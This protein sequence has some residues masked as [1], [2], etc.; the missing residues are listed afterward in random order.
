MGE[1][2]EAVPHEPPTP[3]ICNTPPEHSRNTET[4]TE[5]M[6]THSSIERSASQPSRIIDTPPDGGARAWM[7]VFSTFLVV[8]N[9][10]GVANSF[11]VF[12]PYF[13]SVFSRPQSDVS[14]IGSFEVFLLF[15]VG[16]FT[17]RWTDMGF[18][19]P[20]FIAGFFL[21]ILG[22]VAASFCTTYWQFFLAQGICLGLGNGCL[23]CPCMAVTSTYFAKRRSLA[24]G[25]TAAGA[26]VGGLTI[27]SMVRQLLPKIGLGWTIRAIALI[28]VVT[29]IVAGLLIKTRIPPR[30]AAPLVEWAAFQ[31]SEYSFYAIGAFMCFWG[32]Y[33]AFHFLA[34]FSRDILGL[35][36]TDS[37]DLLLVLNGVGALG[38][39]IPAQIGDVIGTINIFAPMAFMTGTVMFCWIGVQNTT[40]LYV[41]TVFYGFAVGGVQSLFPS[42]LSSL[43]TDPQKQGT[44]MG[45]VFTV[46][47]F[48]SLTGS[49]IAGAIIDAM[50]GRYVGAQAFAGCCMILG[51][52]FVLSARICKTRKMGAGTFAFIKV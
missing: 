11:G 7:V 9:T 29:L 34:A 27:P 20:L 14:W 26:V 50:G 24:F 45:M 23:F 18:F 46:V 3:K 44:R 6:A 10:W 19:R 51:M 17:G 40:G 38:R 31:E 25:L 33:F 15:F 22:M 35:S 16:T 8:M 32:T 28:Q 47:S 49:P 42:V 2:P 48:A 12:Q 39:I 1:K 4:S 37:L 13:T 36:Y 5:R 41:W 21:V 30:Q 43:T 52:A